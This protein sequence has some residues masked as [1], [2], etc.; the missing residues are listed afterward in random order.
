VR[1]FLVSRLQFHEVDGSSHS[2]LLAKTVQGRAT[3]FHAPLLHDEHDAERMTDDRIGCQDF[4]FGEREHDIE[5][6]A[7]SQFVCDHSAR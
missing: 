2:D 7:T 5:N 6:A 1:W 3:A 4:R